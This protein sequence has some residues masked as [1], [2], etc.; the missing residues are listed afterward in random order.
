VEGYSVARQPTLPF[1]VL[2]NEAASGTN[3]FYFVVAPRENEGAGG[4]SEG[5]AVREA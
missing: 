4:G 5:R 3:G 2:G 1:A